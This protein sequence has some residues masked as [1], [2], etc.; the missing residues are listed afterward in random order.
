MMTSAR[1]RT[2][3]GAQVG[4]LA[5]ET[6]FAGWSF[7]LPPL[8]AVV[9]FV[10]AGCNALLV[11]RLGPGTATGV[12]VRIRV[13]AVLSAVTIVGSIGV[14]TTGLS[15]VRNDIPDIA[16]ECDTSY[17]QRWLE[18]GAIVPAAAAMLAGLVL[19]VL[20]ARF[21]FG[22]VLR[23]AGTA[24]P[25]VHHAATGGPVGAES[26]GPAYRGATLLYRKGNL[27]RPVAL[28]VYDDTLIT[29]EPPLHSPTISWN[30]SRHT[31]L[32]AQIL[33]MS[34]ASARAGA[35]SQA[36][37]AELRSLEDRNGARPHIQDIRTADI[38]CA[39][40]SKRWI[41]FDRP[42]SEPVVFAG[43]RRA[44]TALAGM[45]APSL[46]DRLMFPGR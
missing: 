41:E 26:T 6:S 7:T 37:L 20:V 10:A 32:V 45:L 42:G 9:L 2:G 19:L 33:L 5:A 15:F 39:R 30:E 21:W 40:V 1:R 16:G 25:V 46:G 24:Q 23:S 43:S 28:F 13:G 17:G 4:C 44:R 31:N 27:K 34:A 12:P 38:R 14:I 36:L 8:I 29:A 35:A 11:A 22:P 18:A 3:L